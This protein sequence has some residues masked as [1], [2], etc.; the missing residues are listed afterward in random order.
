MSTTTSSSTTRQ[1]KNVWATLKSKGAIKEK[2]AY[3]STERVIPPITI[4]RHPASSIVLN[5][6]HVSSKHATL[7][8]IVTSNGEYKVF[9]TETSSNGTY[10][11][12]FLLKRGERTELNDKDVLSLPCDE[13]EDKNDYTFEFNLLNNPPPPFVVVNNNNNNEN[14]K[15]DN[16]NDNDD[17]GIGAEEVVME[18]IKEWTTLKEQCEIISRETARL[19]A[20]VYSNSD[21]IKEILSVSS[22]NNYN[23]V[24]VSPVENLVRELFVALK[25]SNQI[26]LVTAAENNNNNTIT[27][28]QK[29]QEEL[30]EK[31]KTIFGKKLLL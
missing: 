9:V 29:T 24:Y 4:G 23:E 25:K 13:G 10:L 21:V 12:G 28:I 19:A 11:N 1:A 26:L 3:F 31:Y 14:D 22:S 18:T 6:P 30:E 5:D 27:T 7:E 8:Q 20:S 17:D 15:N 2:C 16:N